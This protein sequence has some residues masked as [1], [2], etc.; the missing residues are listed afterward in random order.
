IVGSTSTLAFNRIIQSYEQQHYYN[1]TATLLDL[2]DALNKY[3]GEQ[4]PNQFIKA[5]VSNFSLSPEN[6]PT[7]TVSIPRH[8]ANV[9]RYLPPRRRPKEH[10]P[11]RPPPPRPLPPQR[12]PKEHL[13]QRR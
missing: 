6:Y 5:V 7:P 11:P 4:F 12:R 1:T 10:L 9:L 13:Q 2:V 3:L 8:A